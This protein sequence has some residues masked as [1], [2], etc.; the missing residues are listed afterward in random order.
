MNCQPTETAEVLRRQQDGSCTKVPC[1]VAIAA[2]NCLM[3]G[4]DRNDQT[5]QYYHVRLKGRKYY[6]YIFWFMFEA[7]IANAYIL[8]TRYC[9]ATD[10]DPTIKSLLYFRLQLVKELIGEYKSQK[11]PGHKAAAIPKVLPLCHFPRKFKRPTKKRGEPVLVL[12]GEE[13]S[14][15]QKRDGV[16]LQ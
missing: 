14:S 11:R 12:C 3:G 15:T 1:P 5:R 13:V 9:I 6:K 16:V 8:F 7:S 10:R 4:V 2:Y